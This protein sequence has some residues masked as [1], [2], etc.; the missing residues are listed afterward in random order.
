M[1]LR[2]APLVMQRLVKRIFSVIIGDGL[3]THLDDLIVVS[4][5]LPSHLRKLA[6][7]FDKLP[8]AGLKLNPSKCS[9]LK[10][11]VDFLGYVIDKD[12]IHT[13]DAK[14]LAAKNF[15]TP[16]S[17]DNVR[18]F[19]GLAGYFRPFVRHFAS[20]ASPLTHLFKKDVPFSWHD[21]QQQNFDAFKHTLT[22]APVLAFPDYDL[23][24]TLCTGASGRGIGAVLMQTVEG[25]HPHVIA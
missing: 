23:P 5:D 9:F 1:G 4:K 21:V 20:I 17:N 2:N 12:G 16:Q 19:L 15:S 7:V 18:S 8:N 24:F 22:L 25:R 3:F 13:N 11:R 14:I 6:L 10:F